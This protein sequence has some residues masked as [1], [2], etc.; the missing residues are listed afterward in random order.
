M[1]RAL[2]LVFLLVATA[3]VF[4]GMAAEAAPL[5]ANAN[6]RA[7]LNSH[8]SA[9]EK[10]ARSV[11]DKIKHIVVL[12]MENRSFDHMFGFYGKDKGVNGLT[13][14]EYN[15]LDI[16]NPASKK[17]YVDDKAPFINKC[18]PV[19]DTFRTTAKLYGNHSRAEGCNFSCVDMHAF[20]TV[21][22]VLGKGKPANNYCNV[23]Q[24]L[25]NAPRAEGGTLPV[26]TALAD[27]FVLMDRFFCS[28]PGATWP[29]RLLHLAATAGGVTETFPWYEDE[30]GRLFPHKTILDQVDD[31]G[32]KWRVYYNDTPWEM[33]MET[34][35]HNP[36]NLNSMTK[37]FDD[38]KKGTL[39]DFSFINPRSGV[40]L[41]E[42]VGSNDHHPDHD[43]R[44]GEQYYK[45]IYEALRASKS[46]N[47]TLFII[48]YDEHGGFYDHVPPPTGVP[49]PD[50]HRN[51]PDPN[52]RFDRLG[53]RIPTLLISPWVQKG[54]VVSRAPEAQRPAENSEYDLTSIM[55]S[56][57]K[58]LRRLE[59]APALTRR[60]A[61]ASTFEHVLEA[62]DEPRTDCP[63]HLPDPE[64]PTPNDLAE[65]AQ[66]P[67]NDLQADI[68]AVHH[69]L[70]NPNLLSDAMARAS[71]SSRLPSEGY[72]VEEYP[73]ALERQADVG[74]YLQQSFAAHKARTLR[75][76]ASKA[77]AYQNADVVALSG[78]PIPKTV[79]G[80][81][82]NGRLP[83]VALFEWDVRKST[84]KKAPL[85]ANPSGHLFDDAANARADF[86]VTLSG[87]LRGREGFPDDKVCLDAPK[88][89]AGANLSVS[90]CYPS[91]DPN[92]N[93]DAQQ[94]FY[95]APD[96]SIRPIA[97]DRLCV[98]TDGYKDR[99]E[100]G[101]LLFNAYLAPCD[102]SN[103]YQRHG[104]DGDAPGARPSNS[105]WTGALYF[106]VAMA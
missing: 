36:E 74:A 81:A 21:E 22:A 73:K 72:D 39:P 45:D 4:A 60:D 64:P 50:D 17:I 29:N 12:M 76:R 7:P 85:T 92:T 99:S 42:R 97:D 6:A 2:I 88:A 54:A 78:S 83:H 56:A 71:S 46:W 37:F 23:M 61:W 66:Q 49:T 51:Y 24:S 33:F 30:P 67:I 84:V 98:T 65:E 59:G 102:P 68:L 82:P 104:Y 44:A 27:E 48:T 10:I 41:T 38:C 101:K 63:M 1:A 91:A 43:I 53:V 93:R 32:G 89:V 25:N 80:F 55:A 86:F 77:A 9:F 28:M 69:V 87:T 95:W 79:V 15:L 47:E 14:K 96:S 105:I 90:M 3:V 106:V 18:D 70:A 13:G 8:R 31:A 62:L 26:L 58:I 19:H 40:N 100:N 11:S 75:W 34:I 57:R 103:V 52:F 16:N 35:A 94:Q 5:H 20:V